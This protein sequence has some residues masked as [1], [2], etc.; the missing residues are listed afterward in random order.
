MNYTFFI[1]RKA[2]LCVL[3]LLSATVVQA[4]HIKGGW[5]SYKYLGKDGSGNLMYEF[6]VKV[7]RDCGVQSPGQNDNIINITLFRNSD[8][9]RLESAF[10]ANLVQ[11]SR[12]QKTTFSPCISPVPDVC[13]VVLEYRGNVTVAPSARG[14]TA[15]F[16]RCCRI[17]GIVNVAQ[18]SNNLGNTYSIQLPGN[19]D[20]DKYL[21]N[22]S[23]I[24]AVKDTAVVCFNSSLVLDFSATDPDGDSL[25]YE[26]GPAL[27]GASS[28]SPAPP[29]AN[30]PINASL[31]YIEGFS[32]NNPFGTQMVLN[33][34]TGIITGI[35]PR[36]TG[37]YVV[38]VT[39]KE[40]RDGRFIAS[41]RK[42]LH[43]NVANCSIPD[44][45]LPKELVNCDNFE[46]AFENRS[47][48]PIINSYYW[49]LGV[50]GQAGNITDVTRPVFVYPDTGTYTVK[51]VV[52]RGQAC[53]DSANMLVK[54]YPGFNPGF[55]YNG[56]CFSNP[57][58]F[59]DTTSARYGAVNSWRWDF[60]N[61]A[62]NNDTSIIRNPAYTFP[63]PGTYTVKL[64][65]TSTK[66]CNKTVEVPV[67][68]LDKP[69]LELP[70]KDTLIC[71]I[72]TLQLI[73]QGTGIFS[74]SPSTGRILNA[75]TA[76]PLV[77]PLATTSYVVSLDDRGCLAKD[78]LTVHVL[79]FITVD[80]GNDTTICLGDTISLK[81][82]T[83]GLSF[84]WSPANTL[85]NTNT[86]N[87]LATPQAATTTYVVVANLGKC[88][89]TDSVRISTVPYP[90][91]Y[92]GPDS[93]ICFGA[94]LVLRGN[95]NGNR[96]QWV[97]SI[98][99]SAPDSLVTIAAPPQTTTYTLHVFNNQGCP[100][101]GLSS[102]VVTVNPKIV[103]NAGNDTTIVFGQPLR[104]H[105]T[106][107]APINTWS[108]S[109]GL[110]NVNILN[111]ILTLTRSVVPAG[112][113]SIVL[114]IFSTTPQGCNSEDDLTVRIFS[115]GPAIFVPTA[116]TP[117]GDG[118]NDNIRPV[119]AGVERLDFFRIFNRYGQLVF[120]SKQPEA[121]WDGTLKGK[122]QSSGTFVYQV[123]AIDYTG[124]V[125]KQNGSFILIR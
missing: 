5:M 8:N 19:Q 115:T 78:T 54:I 43:V 65:S 95:G 22:S 10:A 102:V 91:S 29:L 83:A 49:E 103:V 80:A 112:T 38:S 76:T 18:P 58:V 66:G 124:E 120:E 3:V 23:P 85:N 121:S 64:Q 20:G 40:Y 108:P 104:L 101:P 30:L 94:D 26:F 123:Q 17:N 88:Q 36:T 50:P 51:L 7:F 62:A 59:T 46:V 73:A 14:Y 84:T 44:A 56:S 93:T 16:Q 116:F 25:V 41:T 86:R 89:D 79:D 21:E 28:G 39:V 77:Y 117:N 9:S 52:N 96:V 35:S 110:S 27:S 107:N 6:T 61:T 75:N 98:G 55:T 72:D 2:I 63:T 114:K 1:I 70:F 67:Q 74:W 113:D 109:L 12:L 106:S 92:A 24:F 57:F 105:A 15:A 125:L 45:D 118:L 60:G 68:V 90:V 13:Y 4:L 119:L 33:T 81:P 48:S 97:P 99:L 32:P 31:P 100:K 122:T 53:T 87:P 111:P 71:S 42:E 11:N 82:I 69:L 37:E 34:S 47:F